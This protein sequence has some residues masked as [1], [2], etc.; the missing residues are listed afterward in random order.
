MVL[1][2]GGRRDG[3]TSFQVPLPQ[4][5]SIDAKSLLPLSSQ[6]ILEATAEAI[7]A[8]RLLTGGGIWS[9]TCSLRVCCYRTENNDFHLLSPSKFHT[10]TFTGRTLLPRE[11]EKCASRPSGTCRE[12][13]RN[14]CHEPTDTSQHASIYRY[15]EGTRPTCT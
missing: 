12:G 10:S 11:S 6:E 13:D 8:S 4:L 3:T 1:K 9:L 14:G 5:L 7:A 15:S 2:V